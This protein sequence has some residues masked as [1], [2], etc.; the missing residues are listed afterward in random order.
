MWVPL[1]VSLRTSSPSRPIAKMCGLPIR[2]DTKAICRLSGDQVG[3]T[4]M[5]RLRVSRVV[6]RLDLSMR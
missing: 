5:A 6:F 4:S 1:K 2:S 3:A